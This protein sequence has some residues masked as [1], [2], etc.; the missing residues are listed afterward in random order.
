[1]FKN[2]KLAAKIASG[3]GILIA[4]ALALGGMAVFNMQEVEHSTIA[5]DQK[6]VA[7][8][9]ILSSLE[10][11]AQRTMYNMRGYAMSEEK[12]YLKLSHNDLA[13]VKESLGKAKKLS[14]R[15][16]E[17]V[18]LKKNIEESFSLVATYEDLAKKTV[19]GNEKLAMLRHKMDEA[20]GTYMK[21][22]AEYLTGQHQKIEKA[23]ADAA[24]ADKLR[25]RVFKITV[26][27]DII[28][29]GNDTRVKNF[30]SQATWDPE[31]IEAGLKNFPAMDT[32]FTELR[33]AS[34][35][36]ED[37]ERVDKTKAAADAYKADMI[38]FLDT[39][40]KVRKLGSERG[41]AADALLAMV[42]E[43]SKAGLEGLRKLSSA[44]VS[45]LD[46]AMTTML[47]GLAV[48]LLIGVI[49]A[50][51]ITRSI[52]KPINT[53]I[54]GLSAGSEQVSAASSQVANASQ[55]LAQGAAEQAAGLE[56][57][58]SSME[59]MGSM[60]KQNS[61]NASQ[62]D[63]L[64]NEAGQV[65]SRAN[66]A[67]GELTRSMDDISKAGEETGKIIKTIDE[68][69]FQTN[70]LALNAAV[71]AARAGEAGAGFAVVADEV[72]NLAMRA[73]EAAKNTADLIEGTITKTKQGSDLVAKTNESFGEVAETT[74]KVGE[75]VSEI[76]A[77]SAEQTQGIEQVNVAMTQMDKVTQQNAANAEE[78]AAAAEELSAQAETMQGFVQDLIKLVGSNGNGRGNKLK[79]TGKKKIRA[80]PAPEIAE[81]A[82]SKAAKTKNAKEAIPLDDDGDFAD[83]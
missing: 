29:L 61:D 83:F 31:L 76:A 3:F 1:M 13:L 6:Y 34:K 8:V 65:V 80:L 53:V 4:I 27:N 47:I 56:E 70:L 18:V 68:I 50:I 32:K 64:S 81:Q 25:D 28:D 40:K 21:T 51:F 58:S 73:A 11:R 30:K 54:E 69:A 36:L 2:L 74:N 39:W 17:L 42:R 38:Q 52:T 72:R 75:L 22:C 43:T 14:D 23:I 20:A 46:I 71:E 37:I 7:E 59:E 9:D 62:A 19:A 49:L 55:S 12:K 78:S 82:L 15:F 77:A 5:M 60:T 67:M 35:D 57:T 26:V 16:P 10:R 24:G 44:N 45:E 33:Q 79:L 66:Q 63:S 48:A 41:A